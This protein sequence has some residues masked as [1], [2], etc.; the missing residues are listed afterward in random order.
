[1]IA[2]QRPLWEPGTR[3]GYHGVSLG[4]YEGELIRRLDPADRTLGRFFAE[5]IAAPLGL[6]VHFG[7]PDEVGPDRIARIERSAP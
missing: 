2:R 1:M 4:W 6:D 7:V 5:E 3:H